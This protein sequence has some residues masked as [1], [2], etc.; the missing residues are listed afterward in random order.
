LIYISAADSM[1]LY[2]LLF[3]QLSLKVGPSESKSAG[4]KTEFDTK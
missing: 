2:L 4:S 3:T 1:A